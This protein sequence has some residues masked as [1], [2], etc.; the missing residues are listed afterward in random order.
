MPKPLL[1]IFFFLFLLKE[2]KT[3]TTDST[4]LPQY[5]IFRSKDF[6]ILTGYNQRKYGFGEIGF[7][8]NEYGSNRHPFTFDY[9]ISNEFNFGKERII[10]PKIG[11]WMGGG[12][13]IGLSFIYYTNFTKSCF[14]F[15]PE[16]GVAL[17]K[18][19]LVYG[20]NWNWTKL[21]PGINQ[22]MVS[23]VYCFTLKQ[24]KSSYIPGRDS[25]PETRNRTVM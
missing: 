10:G 19:K 16:C 12:F 9:F 24:L 25:D 5:D 7:V 22:N 20:Y 3:Q 6:S 2:G 14:V 18:F 8:I 15:R 11:T 21:L 4:Y 1:T 13:G 23:F 17:D